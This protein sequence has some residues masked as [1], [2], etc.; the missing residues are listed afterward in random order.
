M[1]K[2]YTQTK[3]FNQQIVDSARQNTSYSLLRKV[4]KWDLYLFFCLLA[5]G[6]AAYFILGGESPSSRSLAWSDSAISIQRSELGSEL[7]DSAAILD[8]PERFTVETYESLVSQRKSSLRKE[9]EEFMRQAYAARARRDQVASDEAVGLANEVVAK[10]NET[11]RAKARIDSRVGELRDAA[12]AAKT[13][14]AWL[15]HLASLILVLFAAVVLAVIAL[16]HYQAALVLID[17]ADCQVEI[18]AR[19]QES[20]SKGT[21]AS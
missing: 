17:F 14:E 21:K 10:I 16:A 2:Y 11:S 3:L 15:I 18:F 1:T 4:L 7:Q 9:K 19:T 8:I 12:I 5:S 13:K 20:A 6:L